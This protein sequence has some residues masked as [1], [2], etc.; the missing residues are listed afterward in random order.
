[1]PTQAVMDELDAQALNEFPPAPRMGGLGGLGGFFQRPGVSNV[2]QA[3]GSSLM[4]SPRNNPMLNFAEFYDRYDQRYQ[5]Q[6]EG[7]RNRDAIKQVLMQYGASPQEADQLSYNADAAE[8]WLKQR[9]AQQGVAA[10]DAFA[11]SLNGVGGTG[12]TGAPFPVGSVG[13]QRKIPGALMDPRPVSRIVTDPDAGRKLTQEQAPMTVP[14]APTGRIEDLHRRRE[15]YVQLGAKARTSEQMAKIRL[16]IENVDKAIEREEERLKPTESLRELAAI[17]QQRSAEGL[18]RYRL[19]EWQ[20]IKARSGG[21]NVNV[22]K[23]EN[24]YDETYNTEMAKRAI[25]LEDAATTSRKQ[26][27]TLK[28][29]EKAVNDPGFYSGTGAGAVAN[30]KRMATSLNIPGADGID[31]VESFNALSKQAALDA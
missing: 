6:Q 26:I 9:T 7:L 17:N 2:L 10:D 20:Q 5:K 11:D 22:G 13:G 21:T 23:G 27:G 12:T 4:T 18:P 14:G 25:G 3:L 31:S 28:L 29:M 19:D 15:A 16:N 1:M 24:K 8:M 30:L